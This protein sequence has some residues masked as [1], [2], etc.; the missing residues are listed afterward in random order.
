MGM[1]GFMSKRRI[2]GRTFEEIVEAIGR[3]NSQNVG[4]KEFRNIVF[5]PVK[6][7]LMKSFRRGSLKKSRLDVMGSFGKF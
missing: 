7:G 3:I 6:R 5:C 4:E 1:E 2:K